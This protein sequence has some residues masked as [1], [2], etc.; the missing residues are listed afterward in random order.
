M[1]GPLEA[2]A[3]ELTTISNAHLLR[4]SELA[5]APV[6]DVDQIDYLFHRPFSMI[7]LLLKKR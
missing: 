5:Q 1:L 3:R 4:H 6:T 2:E 7:Q